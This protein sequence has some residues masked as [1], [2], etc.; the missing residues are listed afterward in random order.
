MTQ[1]GK[2]LINLRQYNEFIRQLMTRGQYYA[3]TKHCWHILQIYPKHVQTHRLLAESYLELER[4]PDSADIFKRVLSAIPDDFVAHL[5]LSVIQEY[6]KNLEEAI[7]HMELAFECRPSID[8]IK[9]ELRRLYGIRDGIEPNEVYLTRPALARLYIRG[10]LYNQA[11]YELNEVIAEKPERMDLYT[12]LAEAYLQD[13]QKDE[14]RKIASEILE[15][16]PYCL[17]AN[18]LLAFSTQ[19]DSTTPAGNIYMKRLVELDPYYQYMTAE[20]GSLEM[21]PDGRINLA[22]LEGYP[23]PGG[24]AS[25]PS[26]EVETKEQSS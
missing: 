17:M 22:W 19:Q 26:A 1:P 25:T 20:T 5:G 7:W 14:A 10:G 21:I 23:P 11:I 24:I 16:M 3:A 18:R 15:K 12:L 9:E 13:E 6:L 2:F 8:M 4:Y